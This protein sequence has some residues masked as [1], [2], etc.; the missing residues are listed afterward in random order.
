MGSDVSLFV[1][2][3]GTA[4]A[5][6]AGLPGRLVQPRQAPP[7]IK[8]TVRRQT[9]VGSRPTD[10]IASPGGT[11]RLASAHVIFTLRMTLMDAYES[12]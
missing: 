5:I 11:D 9:Y 7:A 12:R 2:R 1:T 10:S 6:M 3:P 8:R 4:M